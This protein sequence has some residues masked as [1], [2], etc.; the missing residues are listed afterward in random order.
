VANAA[1]SEKRS[2]IKK[3]VLEHVRFTLISLAAAILIIIIFRASLADKFTESLFEKFH[4]THLFFAAFTPVAIYY[5]Y[6]KNVLRSAAIGIVSSAIGCTV[7]DS[8]FPYLGGSLLGYNMNLHICL[9][10]E[11][12]YAIPSL[13][14]GALLGFTVTKFFR[15]VTHFTHFMHSFI[16][17]LTSLIYLLAFG[18][19]FELSVQLVFIVIILLIS[20]V[21]P[22]LATDVAVPGLFISNTSFN[23]IMHFHNEHCK[24]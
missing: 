5:I 20:V 8:I 4:F 11:P 17:S 13:L 1:L 22:C 16:A 19:S 23:E 7:S 12:Y 24:H 21:V 6:S 2:I 3:E 14:I 10:N 18:A 15:K 9:I